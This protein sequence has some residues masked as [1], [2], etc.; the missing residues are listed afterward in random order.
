MIE[1]VTW[2]IWQWYPLLQVN[3]SS[4]SNWLTSQ[5]KHGC[6]QSSHRKAVLLRWFLTPIFSGMCGHIVAISWLNFGCNFVHVMFYC[7]KVIVDFLPELIWSS[8][9]SALLE[10]SLGFGQMLHPGRWTFVAKVQR[11]RFTLVTL[12]EEE[13]SQKKKLGIVFTHW[14]MDS[15]NVSVWR[16]RGGA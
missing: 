7:T 4:L 2:S 9:C 11:D 10:G 13:K 6:Y 15:I 8:W 1:S 16:G 3:V 5:N 12:I 14:S